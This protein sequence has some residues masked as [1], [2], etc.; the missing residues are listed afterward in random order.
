MLAIKWY[1][2]EHMIY[3][4]HMINI[5][6][7]HV[8]GSL[9]MM[10]VV[11][12]W[13]LNKCMKMLAKIMPKRRSQWKAI[14]IYPDLIWHRC[15]HASE[16]LYPKW[17]TLWRWFNLT[18]IFFTSFQTRWHHEE[19]H[20]NGRG[21]RKSVRRSYVFDYFPEIRTNCYT[22][23]RI[24]FHAEFYNVLKWIGTISISRLESQQHK[25]TKKTKKTKM[26]PKTG[27]RPFC[28]SLSPPPLFLYHFVCYSFVN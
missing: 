13:V 12:H 17:W 10:K 21:W 11:N 7:R 9:A 5:I 25:Q 18:R 15:I 4:L 23:N 22:Y 3:I 19:N 27:F 26:N 6:K 1:E 28:C 24:W 14:Q 8:Y 20:P 16:C 2:H